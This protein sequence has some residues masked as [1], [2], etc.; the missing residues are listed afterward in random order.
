MMS[1]IGAPRPATV[2]SRQACKPGSARR[3][4][5]SLFP[6]AGPGRHASGLSL[7]GARHTISASRPRTLRALASDAEEGVA[8]EDDAE[9]EAGAS[10]EEEDSEE[11]EKAPLDDSQPVVYA[12]C[13]EAWKALVSTVHANGHF[14]NVEPRYFSDENVERPPG[15]VP[16]PTH[17]VFS[18]FGD[19]SE[20]KRA[21]L[22]FG[23]DRADI[24][25]GLY[26]DAVTK[27]ALETIAATDCPA[28]E[29]K[30]IN[31]A[32]RLRASLRIDEKTICSAC[33]HRPNCNR[34][35]NAAQGFA[36]FSDVLR[37]CL[38]LATN[39]EAEDRQREAC[40]TILAR[41]LHLE[42][43]TVAPPKPEPEPR[44]RR[45]E[46]TR[47]PMWG[48]DDDSRESRQSNRAMFF[49][50]KQNLSNAMPG[51]WFCPNCTNH[52]FA[53]KVRA[54]KP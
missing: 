9:E 43:T 4:R 40:A 16:P 20:T 27:T 21:V 37:M 12:D 51:D 19:Y 3:A 33:A 54:S 17:G 25:Q 26:K 50:E 7:A 22:E 5:V 1:S 8:A 14:D 6:T 34:A 53:R 11:P 10:V 15:W 28:T 35:N 41:A 44:L 29:R 38:G 31:S 39:L 45:E 32:K 24:L 48:E 30:A 23:R 47:N 52:V 36:V 49:K 18:E 46:R 13:D 42:R 2:L